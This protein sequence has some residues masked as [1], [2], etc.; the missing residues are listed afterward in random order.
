MLCITRWILTL[1]I[2]TGFSPAYGAPGSLSF[3]TFLKDFLTKNGDVLRA[4]RVLS[5]AQQN[6]VQQ[7]DQWKSRL[8][9]SPELSFEKQKFDSASR[10]DNSNRTSNLSGQLTQ[11]MP[12]GTRLEVNAQ[13]YLETQN[14]LFSSLD[15]S[16]SAKLTQDLVRNSFGK[17]QSAQ[18]DKAIMDYD[19]AELEFRQSLVNSCESAFNLYA[20]AFIQQEIVD[21]L[22]SQ[23]VGAKK[24]VAISRR[25]FK[26]RL[27]NRIDKLS[28][29]S[30]FI[31][32]QLQVQQAEQQLA[33]NK[34]RIQ[35]FLGQPMP[36]NFQLFDPS[37]FVQQ[38]KSLP[39]S[40]TLSEIIIKKRVKSQEMDVDR[41]RS[42]RWTDVELG[43]EV[44]E[45]FGRLS[46]SGPL[47]NY[48]EE[49]LKAS[50]TVGLD[51]INNTENADLKN[52]IY[53]RNSLER[54]N[55]ILT[56]TQR[57]KIDSLTA[58][59]SLLEEQVK[60]SESQVKMLKEK[61]DIAFTQMKRAK[62]DFQNYLLHRNAFLNQKRNYLNLKKD[63]WLN[64]F[65]LQKEFAHSLPQL[66]EVKS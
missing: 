37:S 32:T 22:K 57:S 55:D 59:D 4:Q 2:L 3:N 13:K 50:V 53:V 7:S 66:C 11:M 27:I 14:P 25:L 19:V 17:T 64:K 44:G 35:A 58:M 52:A 21:L 39:N 1:I 38:N 43:L 12:T 47:I 23:Y 51:I 29:E 28:S 54:E 61:M 34:R 36:A 41:A 24:A 6:K 33:N 20:D 9:A 10:N 49:F 65:S 18:K 31:D 15:R 48:N 63:L 8:T 16:Y 30:D 5:S 40:E 46:F 62:L 26:D 60:S 45:R 42:D 56:R